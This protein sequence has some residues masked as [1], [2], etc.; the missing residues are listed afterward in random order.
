MVS[1]ERDQDRRRMISQRFPATSEAIDVVYAV[2]G[3]IFD[4]GNYFSYVTGLYST[5]GVLLSPGEVGCALSHIEAYRRFLASTASAALFLEDDVC[6]TDDDIVRITGLVEKLKGDFFLCCGGQNGL[7]SQ[8]WLRGKLRSYGGSMHYE[9]ERNCYR[10]VWR[11]CCYVMSR[12]VAEE[13]LKKQL[14]ILRKADDWGALLKGT[15]SEVLFWDVLSHPVEQGTS[16][17]EIERR[18]ITSQ[19]GNNHRPTW[20]ARISVLLDKFGLYQSILLATCAAF[21]G[22]ERVFR[23][24]SRPNLG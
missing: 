15:K 20:K 14:T 18:Q 1:L 6:G 22:Y 21:S 8:R 13:V 3:R 7:R 4:A 2:D 19:L 11:T 9:V 17:I 23:K 24:A 10:Q 5:E 12:R 16:G